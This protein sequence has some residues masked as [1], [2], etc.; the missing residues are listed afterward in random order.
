MNNDE[1]NRQRE[2]F[3]KWLENEYL[4][5]SEAIDKSFFIE[6]GEESYYIGGDAL[7]DG[8]S[9]EDCLFFAWEGWKASH[10]AIELDIDWPECNDNH[11]RTGEEGAYARGH[12]DGK[13]KVIIAVREALKSAGLKVKGDNDGKKKLPA[14]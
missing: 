13:D 3:E 5:G 4:W 2:S 12:E 6:C 14:A 10:R 8:R 9:C 7:V 11:W 1:I